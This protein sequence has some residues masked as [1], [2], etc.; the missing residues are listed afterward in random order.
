MSREWVAKTHFPINHYR[1]KV[2]LCIIFY[3]LL[4][5]LKH[6]NLKN[7]YPF[8]RIPWVFL[9][10]RCRKRWK[11]ATDSVWVSYHPWEALKIAPVR[12]KSQRM[13]NLHMHHYNYSPQKYSNINTGLST[14]SSA[15]PLTNELMDHGGGEDHVFITFKWDLSESLFKQTPVFTHMED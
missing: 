13:I 5:N 4:L 11:M 1:S 15:L 3:I 6:F 10:N 14:R 12:G 2:V 8:W 7:L 9:V